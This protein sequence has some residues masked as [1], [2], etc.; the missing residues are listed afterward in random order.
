MTTDGQAQQQ[1]RVANNLT[2]YALR[3]ALI[4]FNDAGDVVETSTGVLIPYHE[5]RKIYSF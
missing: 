2:N 3:R 1:K 4:G 5:L